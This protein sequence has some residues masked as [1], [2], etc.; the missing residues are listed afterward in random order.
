MLHFN[1]LY[2]SGFRSK[3]NHITCIFMQYV[4]VAVFVQIL[5]DIANRYKLLRGYQ[6][7]YFPGWDCHGMPIEQKVLAESRTD[8]LSLSALD[9]RNKGVCWFTSFD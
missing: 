5:K 8:E 9:L 7:H 1:L 6:V 2:V 4:A 3:Y